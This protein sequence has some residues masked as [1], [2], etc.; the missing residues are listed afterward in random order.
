[1]ATTQTSL[2]CNK[3]AGIRNKDSVFS[4]NF[5]SCSDCQN[6]ELFYTGLNSGIGI[7]TAKGNKNIC[8]DVDDNNLIPQDEEVIGIFETVQDGNNYFIVYTESET[9]G[10]LYYFNI[11]AK[12][13]T[14]LVDNL[15]VTGNAC[16]TDFTQGWL[17]MFCFSNGKE[18]KYIY[19][20]TETHTPFQIATD[21]E[22]KLIDTDGRTVSGLGLVVF[23]GR[24]W[25]F[26]GKVLWYSQQEDCRIFNYVDPEHVTSSGYVE[27]VKPI[28]AIALYLGS[29]AIFHRD[30]S[31]LLKQD[32]TTV[33]AIE[34][35]SPGGCASYDSLVFHGTDLYFYDDTK[36]GV[37]SFQQVVNGDKTLGD[38]IALDI[39]DELVKIPQAEVN[40]IRSLSIVTE[41]RNEIWF[42]IPQVSDE[43]KS[44]I[45]IYD[46]HRGEWVKRKSNKINALAVVDSIFYSAGKSIY[47]E[48]T[49]YTFDGEFIPSFYTCTPVNFGADNTLKILYFPPRITL[50]MQHTTEFCVKYVKNYDYL[51]NSRTKI[52]K[53]KSVKNALYFDVGKWDNAYWSAETIDSIYKLSSATFK[54]LEINIFTNEEGQSFSIK[55]LEMSKVKV[56]QI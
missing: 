25:V 4:E 11:D 5:I 19:T 28:T 40:T 56:K 15:S 2:I 51:K 3:F 14:L 33:Y 12:S 10:R 37:F 32:S 27:R 38:N 49:E 47:E 55:N 36:K 41:D 53:T 9:Y 17:D 26:N 45:M 42:L 21:E 48:Y 29:L 24:L 22:V 1:M 6:V 8:K 46:Y 16:G 35:E 18:I 31:E 54:T 50:D 30:S 20:D 44:I 34:D 7:R 13:L 39:Q 23:D 52:V 43:N